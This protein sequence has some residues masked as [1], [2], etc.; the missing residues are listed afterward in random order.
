M[1]GDPGLRKEACA[2]RY[3]FAETEA[4]VE[5][6]FSFSLRPKPSIGA[7]RLSLRVARFGGFAAPAADEAVVLALSLSVLVV[8]FD[9]EIPMLEGDACAWAVCGRCV[10]DGPAW[11]GTP[12]GTLPGCG[13]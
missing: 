8:P 7:V 3:R 13:A 10:L 4:D 11:M 5:G 1:Y 6:R 2:Q 12:L 9:A